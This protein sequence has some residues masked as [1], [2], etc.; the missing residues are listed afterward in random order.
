MSDTESKPKKKSLKW[1]DVEALG[2]NVYFITKGQQ[3]DQYTKTTEAIADYVGIKYGMV[4]RS[5]V[6]DQKEIKLTEPTTPKS[7]AS[8][9]EVKKWEKE[10]DRYYK[11]VDK[12]EE[13]KAKVF[14][15]IKGQCTLAMKNKIEAQEDYQDIEKNYEVVALLKSIRAV[16][17]EPDIQYDHKCAQLALKRLLNVKQFENESLP[18]Y[19][20]R[21]NGLVEVAEMH[22]GVLVPTKIAKAEK[23]IDKKSTPENTRDKFIACMFIEG[24]DQKRFGKYLADLNN[25]YMTGQDNYPDTVETG[26][27]MLSSYVHPDM[28]KGQKEANENDREF[29]TSF[30][31]MKKKKKRCYNCGKRGHFARDCPE[32][33]NSDDDGNSGSANQEQSHHARGSRVSWSE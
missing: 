27:Q 26:L 7:G 15:V 3:A 19:Y 6:K 10:L 2:K 18:K 21:F 11:K 20:K 28:K 30:N 4:M 8:E 33:E 1:G 17:Y 25:D 13:D 9:L 24:A 5:L 22:F 16:A 14:I 32:S 23:S 31:Q 29:T 12:Y